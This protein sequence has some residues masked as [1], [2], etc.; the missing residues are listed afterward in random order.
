MK[1]TTKHIV[2]LVLAL[3]L[4]YYMPCMIRL[5]T[6]YP[7]PACGT[8]RAISLLMQGD[9]IA[10]LQMNPYGAIVVVVGVLS[11]LTALFKIQFMLRL[12]RWL[13]QDRDRLLKLIL[14][15]VVLF[16]MLLNWWWNIEKYNCSSI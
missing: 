9:F 1:T 13:H 16:L 5:I 6:G 7:C 14:L 3:C 11:L 2:R 10:S 12:W 15:V 8:R 4:V